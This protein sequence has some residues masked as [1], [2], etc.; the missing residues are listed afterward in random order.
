MPS[1][2]LQTAVGPVSVPGVPYQSLVDTRP[3]NSMLHRPIRSIIAYIGDLGCH[4]GGQ[5]GEVSFQSISHF[6]SP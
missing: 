2:L 3:P 1:T 4:F 6:Y 5:R